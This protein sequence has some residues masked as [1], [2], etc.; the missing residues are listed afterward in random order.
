MELTITITLLTEMVIAEENHEAVGFSSDGMCLE[1]RNTKILSDNVLHKYFK[2]K[3]VSSFIRQLNNYGF[4]A[5][6]VLMNSSVAHCF[7]HECFR[8][9]RM[10]LLEGVTR[11]GATPNEADKMNEKLNTMKTKETEIEQRMKQLKRVNEQLVQQNHELYEENKRLKASWSLLQDTVSRMQKPVASVSQDQLLQQSQPSSQ[12]TTVPP[13]SY[14]F[15][16]EF[17]TPSVGNDYSSIQGQGTFL[18]DEF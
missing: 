5:I 2:H 8:R 13:D 9:G 4:K 1:I 16:H 11:R 15:G 3:N 6:P 10:D 18:P 12:N 14:F 17:S 7:A